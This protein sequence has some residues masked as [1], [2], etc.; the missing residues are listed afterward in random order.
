[1]NPGLAISLNIFVG[2]KTI[3]WG[4]FSTLWIVVLGPLLGGVLSTYFYEIIYRPYM[5]KKEEP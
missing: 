4:R 2:I 5:I 1:L 3:E